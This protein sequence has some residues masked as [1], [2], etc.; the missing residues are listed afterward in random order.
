MSKFKL[1]GN[2][3]EEIEILQEQIKEI[4]PDADFRFSLIILES[5]EKHFVLGS[6]V[7]IYQELGIEI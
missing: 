2:E 5:G 6:K 7:E 1:K 3:E 4:V